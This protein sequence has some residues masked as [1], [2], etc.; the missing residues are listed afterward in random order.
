MLDGIPVIDSHVHYAWP[1]TQMSLA[2][3]L[4]ENGADMVCLAALPGTARL[5][6]TPE[7]LAFKHA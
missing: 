4:A 5:D 3:V 6:P 1:I 7:I 2:D